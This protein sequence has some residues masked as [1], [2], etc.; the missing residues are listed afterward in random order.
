[1]RVLHLSPTDR[2]GGAARGV[3]QLHQGLRAAGVDSL[4]LVQRKF[5]D[6]PTVFTH[7]RAGRYYNA[8]YERLDRLPL[9]L[10]D[11]TRGDWWTV[12]WLPFNLRRP[13]DRLKPDIVQ[14]HWIG[15]GAAPIG[16][17]AR[18]R[19]Y[20][21]VWTLRDMWTLTGGCHYSDDCEKFL[22]GCGACPQ[23]GSRRSLDISRWQWHRKRRAW[24]DL[25][26][27]Y[28]GLSKWIAD[29][30][31]RS[32]LAHGSRVSVIPN[33]IDVERFVPSDTASARAAWGLPQ[34]KHII[35]SGALFGTFFGVAERRKGFDYLRDALKMLAAQG[36]RDRA[37]VVIFGADN[38]DLD[39]SL[40]VRYVGRLRDDRNLASLYACAD[41]MVVPSLQESFGKT[42]AEAMACGTPVTAFAST[43]LL[44]IV[45]HKKNGYLATLRS[46]EDMAR[47]I[48]WCIDEVAKREGLRHRARDKAVDAFDLRSV[49]HRYVAL[50][51]R[52]LERR[53]LAAKA[54]IRE[55][56]R[57]P[58]A[59]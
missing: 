49:V 8:L 50:Y 31:R 47:G 45:D 21:L 10:Y 19:H 55:T 51:G 25:D 40:E 26:I 22:E 13:I 46:A 15:H 37:L 41:V 57:R 29:Y 16:T 42:A 27:D 2:E 14:F 59:A 18:L 48:A 24:R 54:D 35:L 12:G 6:D 52:I 4:M 17:L 56:A 7:G 58:A 9:R 34:D 1:M 11:W 5:S 32:P 44:D 33:G 28:V 53:G 39:A 30:A 20:P 43:G 36:W 23:L 3:Y 38:G